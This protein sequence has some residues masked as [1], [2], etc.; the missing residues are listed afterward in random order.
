MSEQ[1]EMKSQAPQGEK[2]HYKTTKTNNQQRSAQGKYT[3]KLQDLPACHSSP[4]L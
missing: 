3:F 1:M 4:F 2:V